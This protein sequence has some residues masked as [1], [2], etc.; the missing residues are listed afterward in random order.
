MASRPEGAPS[1][2]TAGYFLCRAVKDSTR[3]RHLTLSQH[4]HNATLTHT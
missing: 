4:N 3:A 2:L 1:P